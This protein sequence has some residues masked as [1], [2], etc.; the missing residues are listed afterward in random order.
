MVQLR[1]QEQKCHVFLRRVELVSPS[2]FKKILS[3]FSFKLKSRLQ[4]YGSGCPAG[5]SVRRSYIL[6]ENPGKAEV[7]EFDDLLFG[8]ENVFRFDVPMDA[9]KKRPGKMESSHGKHQILEMQTVKS[10]S[11]AVFSGPGRPIKRWPGSIRGV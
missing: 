4:C 10:S 7:A 5:G 1:T 9:L 2:P 8:D 3:L 6:T 11:G